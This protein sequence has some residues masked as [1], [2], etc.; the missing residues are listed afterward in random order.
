MIQFG[1]VIWLILTAILLLFV[2]GIIA[3]FIFFYVKKIYK[4]VRQKVEEIKELD[5]MRNEILQQRVK[6]NADDF[7]WADTNPEES[8]SIHPVDVS[9]LVQEIEETLDTTETKPETQKNIDKMLLK[10]KQRKIMEQIKY[11]ALVYKERW[12]LEEYEKKLIEWL[13]IDSEYEDF[14]KMLAD[15]YF[16]IGKHKK[17]LSLLKK[18]IENNPDDHLAIW[19]IGEIYLAK[20]E[21]KT[22]E[23][24]I[25]KSINLKPS[26]PKYHISMVEVLYNTD[27]KLEAIEVLEKVVKLRPTN[28]GYL[29]TLA[30]LYEE[31][32]DSDNAKK[33][34]FRVLEYEP[35]NQKAKSK[36]GDIGEE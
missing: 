11:E 2:I 35:S 1:V 30:D 24:L 32:Q 10:E 4:V 28:I 34:Y 20:G 14:T 33:Y 31:V 21:Y 12:R 22:A 13:A 23:L 9:S 6:E 36:V 17:A 5:T 26:S 15:F 27:R 3:V 16:T 25:E 7:M 18:I 19:Q 8:Q 29:I